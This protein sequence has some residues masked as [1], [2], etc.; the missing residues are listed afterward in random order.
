MR[1][2]PAEDRPISARRAALLKAR[3]SKRPSRQGTRAGVSTPDHSLDDSGFPRLLAGALASARAA[4]DLDQAL[5]Q[6]FT[7]GGHVPAETSR[8]A[9]T[10]QESAA[11]AVLSEER[12]PNGGAEPVFN[13]FVGLTAT[14]KTVVATPQRPRLEHHDHILGVARRVTWSLAQLEEYSERY[15]AGRCADREEA[16]QCR[17]WLSGRSAEG[18]AELLDEIARSNALT[19]P[20][21]IYRDLSLYTNHRERNNLPGKTLWRDSN[22]SMFSHLRGLPVRHWPADD[23]VFITCYWLLLKSGGHFRVEELNGTQFSLRAV[24]E[25]FARKRDSYGTGPSSGAGTVADIE[26]TPWNLESVGGEIAERRLRSLATRTHYRE[27]HGPLL[28]KRE[29]IATPTPRVEERQRQVLERITSATP[30]EGDSPA[31]ALEEF[32]RA[33]AW[34][35]EPSGNFKLGFEHLVYETVLALRDHCAADMAMSRGKRSVSALADALARNDWET[36]CGWELPEFYCCVLP[37]ESALGRFDDSWTALADSVWAI[38]ARMQFNCWHH[39]AGNLPEVPAVLERDRFSPPTMPDVAY[40]S[41]NHHRGHTRNHIR[42]TIRSP[43][44]VTVSGL[45]FRG[46]TDVRLLRYDDVPF[47]EED[48][49]VTDRVAALLAGANQVLATM[50]QNAVLPRVEAFD[51][52][53]HRRWVEDHLAPP[54]DRDR[55]PMCLPPRPPSRWDF[56]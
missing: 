55:G 36:I 49:I 51:H 50:A 56:Q 39:M 5:E 11:L 26:P 3:E 23:A 1:R 20:M 13:G 24:A 37:A 9:L 46:F 43:H 21:V 16:E 4:D 14:G 53:W 35:V 31:E 15:E 19:A 18:V 42:F 25:L 38:S 10:G 32:A 45:E 34:L 7:L 8:A 44:A 30:L 28:N 2:T 54:S 6:L 22:E 52:T 17:S 12:E 33:P 48:L 47:T 40:F 41:D 27:I 29:K